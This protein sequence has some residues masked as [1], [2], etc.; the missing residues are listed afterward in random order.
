[1]AENAANSKV[2]I[3]VPDAGSSLLFAMQAD[4]VYLLGFS[5]E[6]ATFDQVGADVKVV[7]DNGGEIILQNFFP[8]VETRD[9]TLE[10]QDGTLISGRDMASVLAMSLKDFHT[11]GADSY[12]Q[13]TSD[14]FPSGDTETAC[15][16]GVALRTEDLLE[17]PEQELFALLP[18][19]GTGPGTGAAGR[20]AC[21]DQTSASGRAADAGGGRSALPGHF[22]TDPDDPV[23]PALLA[24]LR[25]DL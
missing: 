17:G 21:P 13:G 16:P 25:M 15:P 2:I 8:V 20:T 24:L 5:T 6:T 11:D 14:A 23:D 19:D 12:A 4:T 9:F 10:L 22:E 18:E 7:F 3:P 1:M